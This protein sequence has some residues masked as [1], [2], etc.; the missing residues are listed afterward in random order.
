MSNLGMTSISP[1][2]WKI[3]ISQKIKHKPI[4]KISRSISIYQ[5]REHLPPFGH[6]CQGCKKIPTKN[7]IDGPTLYE[8]ILIAFTNIVK[9]HFFL[10]ETC[11]PTEVSSWSWWVGGFS[12]TLRC[13]GHLLDDFMISSN[14]NPQLSGSFLK[15][16]VWTLDHLG[17]P[18]T[19]RWLVTLMLSEQQVFSPERVAFF[20][21]KKNACI[22]KSG[23]YE[24]SDFG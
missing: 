1:W 8:T 2:L 3:W 24:E 19:L 4:L 12:F 11:L 14:L 13:H 23:R 9:L 5:I 20:F 16:S 6:F 10:N 17:A 15:L 7:L 21:Y 22:S 18:K